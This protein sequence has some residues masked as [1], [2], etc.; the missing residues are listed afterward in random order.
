MPTFRKTYI[1][2]IIA[3][4]LVLAVASIAVSFLGATRARAVFSTIPAIGLWGALAIM[5]LGG[6]FVFKPL[7]RIGLLAMHLGPLLVIAGA[8]WGAPDGQG[9]RRL[10]TGDVRIQSGFMVIPQDRSE[11]KVWTKDFGTLLGELDFE[12]FLDEFFLEYYPA[13]LSE[14]WKF[15]VEAIDQN[16]GHE[17][18]QW[19]RMFADWSIGRPGNLPFCDVELLVED[20]KLHK[21][22]P[23]E[24]APILPAATVRLTRGDRTQETVFQSS[25]GMA[26]D[27]LPLAGLYDSAR[28]WHEAGSP[29]LYFEAP[30]PMIKDYKS[31]LVVTRNGEQ[32]ARKTIEVNS[33]LHH[34]GYHFYQYDYD[35]AG[36]NYTVLAVVSD[37]GLW[38]IYAG[39]IIL[40]VGLVVHLII[41]SAKR[42]KGDRS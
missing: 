35:Q 11:N 9:I 6:P 31:K 41:P 38:A 19:R 12:I 34:G 42:N 40:A 3:L 7:R 25:A 29:V 18:V 2:S 36:G 16:A 39:F 33:P 10:L 21:F 26:Y 1:S 4:L 5:L 20:Y 14:H 23:G 13:D 22:G 32:I 24:E 37:S 15:S 28:A 17:R 8:M 27:R 30:A